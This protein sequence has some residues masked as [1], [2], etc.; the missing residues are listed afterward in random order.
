MNSDQDES[1]PK[2]DGDD[3]IEPNGPPKPVTINVRAEPSGMGFVAQTLGIVAATGVIVG[4]MTP[5]MGSTRS[6]RLRLADRQREIDQAIS[7]QESA[8]AT[9]PS[10]DSVTP[11]K[12]RTAP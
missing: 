1:R 11:P 7:S 12:P 2:N 3:A 8:E 10:D 5:S 4:L 6:S 9:S